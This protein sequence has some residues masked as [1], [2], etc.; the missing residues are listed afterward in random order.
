[1]VIRA[2]RDKESGATYKITKEGS[3]EFNP[4]TLAPFV[5]SYWEA[6]MNPKLEICSVKLLIDVNKDLQSR[7]TVV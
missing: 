2:F 6:M 4:G 5:L 1:M 7:E 3:Y